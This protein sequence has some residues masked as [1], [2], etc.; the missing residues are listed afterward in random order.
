MVRESFSRNMGL[1]LIATGLLGGCN[2]SEESNLETQT[3]QIALNQESSNLANQIRSEYIVKRDGGD[4][5]IYTLENVLEDVDGL[6]FNSLTQFDPITKIDVIG[7]RF[8]FTGMSGNYSIHVMRE[9][10]HDPTSPNYIGNFL[11]PI[12]NSSDTLTYHRRT[13]IGLNIGNAHT[14]IYRILEHVTR[15]TSPPEIISTHRMQ[16]PG[17]SQ[18]IGAGP[19]A[20]GVLTEELLLPSQKLGTH[21]DLAILTL[22]DIYQQHFSNV[23]R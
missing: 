3:N 16:V 7:T 8:S 17:S 5:T 9:L 19:G 4:P 23:N 21:E 13:I 15:G 1:A 18:N 11:D 20:F 12:P 2:P 10:D 22:E 14:N 6:N